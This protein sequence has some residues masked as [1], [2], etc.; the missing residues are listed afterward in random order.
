MNFKLLNTFTGS[1]FGPHLF[2]VPNL[3]KHPAAYLSGKNQK[4][5]GKNRTKKDVRWS[6]S[7][8]APGWD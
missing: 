1:V 4:I 5:V 2:P 8:P 6:S 7:P 3:V